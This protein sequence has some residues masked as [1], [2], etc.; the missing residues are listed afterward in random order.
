MVR[1]DR[2]EGRGWPGTLW[3]PRPSPGTLWVQGVPP[4]P[5]SFA[6]SEIVY[7]VVNC[8][9]SSL[10]VRLDDTLNSKLP[11]KCVANSRR[12]LSTGC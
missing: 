3:V 5:A 1:P 11:W 9:D 8:V 6:Q 7:G 10:S 12:T 4:Q 2:R